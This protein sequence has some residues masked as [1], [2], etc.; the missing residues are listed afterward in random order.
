MFYLGQ[1]NELFFI[2]DTLLDALLYMDFLSFFNSN[3]SYWGRIAVVAAMGLILGSFISLVTYRLTKVRHRNDF[4]SKA[5][6]VLAEKKEVESEDADDDEESDEEKLDLGKNI[7]F[8]RSKCPSCGVV[9]KFMNLIP[10]FSWFFQRGKCVACKAPISPRYPLIEGFFTFFFLLIYLAFGQEMNSQILIYLAITSI[11]LTMCIYDLEYYYIP[12]FLQ[13]LLTIVATM[14]VV[15]EG[16]VSL[17]L[18]N[19]KASFV[20]LACGLVVLAFFFVITKTEA[21]GEDDMKFFFIAGLMI[22]MQ[23]IVM[24]FMMSGILGILFGSAWKKIKNDI[25]FPFAP[26]ICT[27]AFIC[28]VYKNIDFSKLIGSALFSQGF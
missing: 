2:M 7:G 6:Q 20:Y 8:S 13:Y 19:V 10:I 18:F 15:G 11:M 27:S 21:I 23:N 22:G 3:L 5:N 28:M 26:A 25:T 4:K 9:L 14:L 16:G 17:V 1:P 12:N 24:F